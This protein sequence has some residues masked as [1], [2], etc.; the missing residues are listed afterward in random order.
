LEE[1]LPPPPPQPQAPP[2][3]PLSAATFLQ[4]LDGAQGSDA[5][6][7]AFLDALQAAG[8]VADEAGRR[9]VQELL[10][11]ARRLLAQGRGG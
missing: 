4:R 1:L 11:E 9:E 10:P 5:A 7:N 8:A 2:Q 3:L 6:C